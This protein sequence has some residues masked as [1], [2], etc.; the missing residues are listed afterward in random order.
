MLF[1]IDEDNVEACN[2]AREY[3]DVVEEL[4]AELLSEANLK[5]YAQYNGE[6]VELSKQGALAQIGSFDCA[7]GKSY[8]LSWQEM[9]AYAM[10]DDAVQSSW[11]EIFESYIATVDA[12]AESEESE[13]DDGIMFVMVFCWVVMA[14]LA[15]W[16]VHS[17][18]FFVEP[19]PP[20]SEVQVPESELTALL[21]S[22]SI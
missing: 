6:S 3:P 20:E 22:H 8:L 14:S 1:R 4:M 13:S 18:P 2:A 10:S 5:E 9:T 7:K 16:R 17:K 11:T 19:K 15:T 12:C 21:S